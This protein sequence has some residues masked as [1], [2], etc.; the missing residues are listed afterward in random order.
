M[1]LKGDLIMSKKNSSSVVTTR[2]LTKVM[3]EKRI[4]FVPN[5]SEKKE[6]EM[7]VPPRGIRGHKVRKK[8]PLKW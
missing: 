7:I 3:L 6:R 8:K 1:E 4:M 2:D 5:Y